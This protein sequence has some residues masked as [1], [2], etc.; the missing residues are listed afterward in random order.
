[1]NSR[2]I[3]LSGLFLWIFAVLG[4]GFVALTEDTTRNKIAENER[5]VLLRNLYQLLPAEEL[6]N[7]MAADTLE[8]PASTLLGS[9]QPSTVYRARLSGEPVAAIFNSIAPNGYSG[10]IHLLVGVYV[11]GSLAGVRAVK[12]QETPGL[13]DGIEVRKSDWI[14]DFNGKS[15]DNPGHSKWAVKRDGGVFDQLT[16]ATITPRAIVQ[17]V[18]KTLLYYDQNATV[19]F[20]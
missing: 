3:L 2:Q 12:H 9:E 7:D 4:T 19:V 8:V 18:E 5:R 15:L 13:G 16:G 1:M 11:D 14:L 17:A 10:K 20:N 6:D